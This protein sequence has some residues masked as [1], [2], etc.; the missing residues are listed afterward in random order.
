MHQM[1]QH[2]VLQAA[3]L[4]IVT[5]CRTKM[6]ITYYTFFQSV[7][8]Y[9]DL[10]IVLE[11]INIFCRPKQKNLPFYLQKIMQSIFDCILGG[12]KYDIY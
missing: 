12:Q 10:I 3:V 6:C 8:I 11:I 9:F 2:S 1:P 7:L 4:M 5:L